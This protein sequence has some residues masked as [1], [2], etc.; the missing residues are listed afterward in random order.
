MCYQLKILTTALFSVVMLRRRL[1]RLKWVS[2]AV[3]VL[4][5]AV[6]LLPLPRSPPPPSLLLP[7]VLTA[8]VALAQLSKAGPTSSGGDE[9]D[10]DA[11]GRF[12]GLC[13]VIAASVTSGFSGVCVLRQHRSAC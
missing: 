10:V 9:L 4:R 2:L 13:A 5:C 3:R 7:Q 12:L 1:T 6:P 11:S 8:G